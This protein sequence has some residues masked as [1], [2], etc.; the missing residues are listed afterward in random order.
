MRDIQQ[1]FDIVLTETGCGKEKI[2]SRVRDVDTM[3]A[4]RLF[5]YLM[6]LEGYSYQEIADC[7][8][9]NMSATRTFISKMKSSQEFAW[10]VS[11]A[12]K[13]GYGDFSETKD[14]KND[15]IIL[16]ALKYADDNEYVVSV[17]EFKLAIAAYCG[18]IIWG[19]KGK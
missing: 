1:I 15:K 6:N 9:R 19:M 10:L 3:N 2:I 7:I 12:A 8:N 11:T 4:K 18:A 13:Y 14:S 16:E 17:S 5:V